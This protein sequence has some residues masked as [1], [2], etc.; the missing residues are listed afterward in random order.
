MPQ[1]RRNNDCSQTARHATPA[2]HWQRSWGERN[3]PPWCAAATSR[4][5]RQKSFLQSTGNEKL[6]YIYICIQYTCVYIITI[7][8]HNCIYTYIQYAFTQYT[9][10]FIYIIH[11]YMYTY[12]Y[13]YNI[14]IYIRHI[15]IERT[16]WHVGVSKNWD[17]HITLP[18]NPGKNN[19]CGGCTIYSMIDA[20]N[21]CCVETFWIRFPTDFH[22]ISKDHDS[23]DE[24][25]TYGGFLK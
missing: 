3:L 5:K 24:R 22:Q 19:E 25:C 20:P 11:I 1:F 14:H 23:E 7:Y 18:S 13:T 4:V 8:I 12:T 2:F 9:Y 16:V 10:I 6:G 17:I 15:H 21:C